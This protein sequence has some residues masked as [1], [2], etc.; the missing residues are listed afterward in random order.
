MGS[1]HATYVYW[2]FVQQVQEAQHFA[3]N[4]FQIKFL[5]LTHLM[6]LVAYCTF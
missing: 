5:K 4:G 2:L 1:L 3:F 6:L